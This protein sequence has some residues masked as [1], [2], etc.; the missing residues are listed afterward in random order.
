MTLIWNTLV[1]LVCGRYVVMQY[2]A[3]NYSLWFWFNCVIVGWCL[4]DIFRWAR[5]RLK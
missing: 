2:L 5:R 3:G 4:T 1:A